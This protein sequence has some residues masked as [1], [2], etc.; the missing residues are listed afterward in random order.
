M[1]DNNIIQERF[2][3]LPREAQRVI[4]GFP[5]KE[6][7]EDIGK[8]HE[9]NSEQT[10]SLVTEAMLVIYG[11]SDASEFQVNIERNVG[12]DAST[13]DNLALAIAEEV[14]DPMELDL[15]EELKHPQAEKVDIVSAQPSNPPR[16]SSEVMETP[17]DIHPAIV[18]GEGPHENPQSRVL[19]NEESPESPQSEKNR[20]PSGQDP[21]REPLE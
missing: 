14:F 6:I 15:Q 17:S 16:N 18:T 21:Y 20:Y 5:W 7:V 9:L 4:E 8:I 12:L 13:S 1:N 11:L 19:P 10:E 2:N 3:E